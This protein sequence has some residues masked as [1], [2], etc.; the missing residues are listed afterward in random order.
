L[1]QMIG[2]LLYM[3]PEQVELNALDVDSAATSI[4]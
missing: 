4:A 3:T 1:A 2:T